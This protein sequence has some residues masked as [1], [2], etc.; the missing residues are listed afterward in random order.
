[1]SVAYFI[2]LDNEDVDF[3]TFVNG[4]HVAHFA[5]EM[6]AF[7]NIHGLKP[8][9]DFFSQDAGEFMDEFDDMDI[10]DQEAQWFD[11]EVGIEWIDELIETLASESSE[12]W[13]EAVIEDLNEYKSVLEQARQIGAKWHFEL[14][15]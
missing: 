8:L 3:D 4:K 2:V 6:L 14:D 9:E 1:M 13:V 15:I 11:A 12:A 10:P 7:C 5:N